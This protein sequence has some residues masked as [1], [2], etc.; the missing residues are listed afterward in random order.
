MPLDRGGLGRAEP[1]GD[2]G[3]PVDLREV[4]HARGEQ[5][6]FVAERPERLVPDAPEQLALRRTSQ[7]DIQCIADL[8]AGAEQRLGHQGLLAAEVVADRREA[9]ASGARDVARG[10]AGVA[11]LDDA[12]PCAVQQVLAIAHAPS[13]VDVQ[14]YVLDIC[15]IHPYHRSQPQTR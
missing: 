13:L 11:L 4:L 1:F 2:H 12:A 14:T 5:L 7:R 9:H 10:R 6:A 15:L 3:D 8:D